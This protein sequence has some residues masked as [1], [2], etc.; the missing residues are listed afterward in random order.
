MTFVFCSS[1]SHG[2]SP[3]AIS[4]VSRSIERCRAGE[5]HLDSSRRL[6]ARSRRLL[7]RAWWIS[8]ASDG[9][10]DRTMGVIHIDRQVGSN[11]RSKPPEF[12][13]SFGGKRNGVFSIGKATG[14]QALISL[15]EQLDLPHDELA[16]AQ[17]VLTVQPRHQVPNVALT[18]DLIRK[19]G[20]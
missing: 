2:G 9:Q 17:H 11:G 6:L 15:L 5:E 14:L 12:L 8:G 10:A 4:L 16:T 13:V 18:R 3:M 20:L 1:A 19:L 7:G